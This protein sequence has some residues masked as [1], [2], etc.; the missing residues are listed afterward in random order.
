MI[1]MIM[2]RKLI[3]MKGDFISGVLQ[4]LFIFFDSV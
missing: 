2:K 1:K 4:F 3:I